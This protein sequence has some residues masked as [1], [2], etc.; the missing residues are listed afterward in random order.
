MKDKAWVVAAFVLT[1]AA[2]VLVGAIIVR[3]Y[4]PPPFAMGRSGE[5]GGEKR[6]SKRGERFPIPSLKMLQEQLDLTEAQQQQVSAI[7]EKHR[8]QMH[9]H[10]SKFRPAT[11]ELI[12]Q[13]RAEIESVLTT[14]QLEKFRR[15][16]PKR[17]RR[18]YGM[19]SAPR[20]SMREQRE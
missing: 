1:F 3:H 9:E 18:G 20:D 4:G 12:I 6:F 11:H 8:E 13:M 16:F 17:E 15:E 14:E 19:K 2:G 5:P 10:L 7:V